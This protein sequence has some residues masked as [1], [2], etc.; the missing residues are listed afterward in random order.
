VCEMP[1]V[2]MVVDEQGSTAEG[3]FS[4]GDG[5]AASVVHA[6]DAHDGLQPA[7]TRA[8]GGVSKPPILLHTASR[9]SG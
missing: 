8:R 9:R 2:S 4:G 1:H 3:M 5:G 7:P 6:A